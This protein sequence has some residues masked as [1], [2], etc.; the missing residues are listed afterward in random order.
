MKRSNQDFIVPAE[1]QVL[2]IL[3]DNEVD[4]QILNEGM[5]PHEEAKALFQSVMKLK[6]KG[7]SITEGSLLREANFLNDD[8]DLPM[9]KSLMDHKAD[10]SNWFPAIET[11][12]KA[13]IKYQL[14]LA[15]N[16]LAET[17][18]L[19]DDLESTGI[20]NSLYEAQQVLS[21]GSKATESK[22][23]EECLD[24]YK[25]VLEMRRLGKYYPFGDQFLDSHLTKK[26]APGQVIMVAGS[27]GTG[28]SAYALN[29]L[30]GMINLGQPCMYFSLEMD[31]ESTFDRLL[32]MRTSVPVEGWYT[33]GNQINPLL[34]KLE[35]ERKLLENKPF[36]FIDDPNV[37]LGTIQSLI[38]EFKMVYRV[39]YN[40]VVIDLVTMVKE[41]SMMTGQK[42]LANAIEFAVNRLN[43]MAKTENVCF[44]C[45]AQMNRE[46]D[47][48]KITE[49]EDID[50]LKPTLNH[51]KNSN[52]MA[53][54]ARTVLSI[55]RGKYYADRYFPDDEAVEYMD[56]IMEVSILK[57]SQGRVGSIGK[58]LFEG[59]CFQLKPYIEADHIDTNSVG[60]Y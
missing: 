29:I 18:S 1:F 55:F 50:K 31:T 3:I 53:E 39:D 52:A 56:D 30:N 16:K 26:A 27:T 17:T 34:R 4:C 7:E 36:R 51:I 38:R 10:L 45:V 47:K 2:K 22:T 40:F 11:L 35:E 42:S 48:E 44:M 6:D 33:S 54:R 37:D 8:I 24:D 21:R 19:P 20:S 41:F 60:E 13:S 46:A 12:R 32:A 9:I 15:F 23:L 14:N 49:I 25:D 58:Y 59:E 5:F 28:K 57:Q 43:A